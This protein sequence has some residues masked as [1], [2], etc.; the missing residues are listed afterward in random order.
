MSFDWR[1]LKP[2]RELTEAHESLVREIGETFLLKGTGTPDHQ[3][4]VE[5][6]KNRNLL[7]ELVQLGLIRNNRNHYYPTF[8]GLYYAP[9]ALRENYAEAL[10]L[11]FKAIQ[12][13]YESS[14]PRQFTIQQVEQQINSLVSINPRP[15]LQY[16]LKVGVHIHRAALFLQDF[17]RLVMVQ[18][19]N[20]PHTP[21]GAVNPIENILDYSDLEQAWRE[22]LAGRSTQSPIVFASPEGPH[23]SSGST[24]EGGRDVP[25]S[26]PSPPA[27]DQLDATGAIKERESG[28]GNRE[29]T[30]KATSATT[31][32]SNEQSDDSIEISSISDVPAEKDA[33]GFKPYVGAISRFLL[34][35]D[36][37]PPLTLSIEGEW[38]SGKSSFML[39]LRNSVVGDAPWARLKKA[40]A[41][42]EAE[43]PENRPTLSPTSA[44][45]PIRIWQAIKTKRRLSVMFNPWRHDKEESLWAAFALEFL[46][47]VSRKRFFLLRWWGTVRLF[48]AHYRWKKGW[49][50]F[51]RA[52]GIWTIM[53]IL[54]VGLP[55]EI[56]LKKPR[57]AEEMVAALS[58]RLN[59]SRDAAKKPQTANPAEKTLQQTQK[60]NPEEKQAPGLDP[61]LRMLLLIGGNAAYVAV[62]LTIWLKAKDIVGNP[63]EINLKK[64]LRSPDYEGRVGF[65]EQFHADFRK[66]VDAYAGKEKVFVFVD[67]LDRC[68][69]PK[70]A[71]LMKAVNLLIADDPRLIFIL[72]MDRDKVAAG[73]AVKYEKMLPYLT[74]QDAST[75]KDSQPN[76][77]FGLEFGHSFLQ[78]FIQLPF[79]VP[80]PN[81]DSYGDFINTISVP[82]E[83]VGLPQNTS[84]Q[85]RVELPISPPVERPVEPGTGAPSSSPSPAQVK[86]R[87]RREIKFRGDSDKVRAVASMVANSISRNPRRLKQFLNLFRL[88]AYIANETGLFDSGHRGE[89]PLTMEQLGKFVAISL[90]WPLLL[91]DFAKDSGLLERLERISNGKPGQTFVD[92]HN[93][94]LA[95]NRWLGE[96]Q[97]G[98]LLNFGINEPGNPY[99]LSN[100]TI[101][102]LLSICPLRIRPPDVPTT[103]K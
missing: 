88:Q 39:Q 1:K 56:L 26:L 42:I 43:G 82:H 8:A 54:I 80:D 100:P 15:E 70:A 87:R 36:T 46:R 57:W 3:K 40:W 17:T 45:R 21:V 19:S 58:E 47:Q 65:V 49:F 64:H 81:P 86:E 31:V 53:V 61:V 85:Q 16:K 30:L 25:V 6:R 52:I 102:Q 62:I 28:A 48:E 7:N 68:E 38:G 11:I 35:P 50:E 33:L 27:E 98:T 12:E 20:N 29:E 4:K 18:E 55:A 2:G 22:E 51:I 14:G 94:P 9:D 72:G 66:I 23:A 13:L 59:D 79:R 92:E 69:V 103:T 10:D 93:N 91:S 34:S 37:K 78:K 24:K 5:L 76:R 60:E 101:Y 71:E 75:G 63:F 89:P 90:W 74:S 99:T 77:R 97:L 67:D 96:R 41:G 32:P 84:P 44:T 73:L 83:L 95:E